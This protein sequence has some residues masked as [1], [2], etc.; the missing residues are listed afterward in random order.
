MEY[1]LDFSE[2]K[3]TSTYFVDQHLV[4]RDLRDSH[5][6]SLDEHHGLYSDDGEYVE[7]S[8]HQGDFLTPLL[9]VIIHGN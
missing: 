6:H 5:R 7:N 2:R 1:W 9:R 8:L 3:Q 4:S